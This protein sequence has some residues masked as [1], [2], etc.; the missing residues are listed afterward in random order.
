[1]PVSLKDR[2]VLVI[3]RGSG[4][5]H[6]VTLSVFDAGG[7]VVVAGRD[8]DALAEAYSDPRVTAER[9]D[10]TDEASVA[11]LA[12]RLGTID[13]VVSTASARARGA[14]GDL[15]HDRVLSSFDTKVVGPILLAKHLAPR[16]PEGGSFV[17]FSGA[18]A[19]KVMPG[20][21]AVGATNAAVDAL[22]RGLA[23]ELAPIRVNAV[24]PGTIDTGA[25]DGLGDQ[26]KAELFAA[27]EADTPAHRV[28]RSDEVADAVLFA[29]TS[30]FTTGVSL[31][32]DG[33]ESLV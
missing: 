11:A 1:M 26:R 31:S 29:L 7:T 5:A 3:G 12:E 25:Y 14:V 22:T 17:F 2:K 19:R 20:M 16:M 18:S 28:G 10:L 21:L 24:S 23:V 9:V 30:T 32:V 8:P 27:R 4:I 13:H 15:A 6:A 33:G